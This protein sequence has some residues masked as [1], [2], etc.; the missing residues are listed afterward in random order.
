MYSPFGLSG[1]GLSRQSFA[2]AQNLMPSAQGFVPQG[3]HFSPIN[4]GLPGGAQPSSSLGGAG[5]TPPAITPPQTSGGLTPYR[6]DGGGLGGG[7]GSV[8]DNFPGWRTLD[9]GAGDRYFG[10]R[11][12]LGMLQGYGGGSLGSFGPQIAPW[13]QGGASGYQSS[14]GRL[15]GPLSGGFTPSYTPYGM[16]PFAAQANS[17]GLLANSP[18]AGRMN[19]LAMGM[20]QTPSYGGPWGSV[21][22]IGWQIA[23]FGNYGIDPV[24]GRPSAN[25]RGGTWVDDPSIDP[26]NHHGFNSNVIG[27]RD[28]TDPNTGRPYTQPK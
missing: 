26:A 7:G 25:P 23:G 6:P 16:N 4:P 20:G 18:Y 22:D 28:G 17:W 13:A 2:P 24:T 3:R 1:L 14:V 27:G 5:G 15:M 8:W 11:D 12:V 21:N 9:N 10:G 19:P